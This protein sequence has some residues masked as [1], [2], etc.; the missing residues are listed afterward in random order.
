MPSL[1]SRF[2]F[3]FALSLFVFMFSYHFQGAAN[4]VYFDGFFII[5]TDGPCSTFETENICNYCDN[6]KKIKIGLR[7]R[8]FF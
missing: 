2:S 8:H 3:L 7:G 5:I 1:I 6:T 4:E